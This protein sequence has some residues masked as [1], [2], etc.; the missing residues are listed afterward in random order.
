[1]AGE[2]QESCSSRTLDGWTLVSGAGSGIGAALAAAFA[3]A[4]HPVVLTDV[5]GDAARQQATLLRARG[6]PAEGLTLDVTSAAEV[7]RVITSL[8]A[9]GK[10]ISVLINNAGLQH[11]SRL[12]DFPPERWGLLV[13]VMLKGPAM[14]TRACLPGMRRLG[15][16][17]V[18]NI[19]SLHS[20]VASPYKSAYIAAKHGLL[21]LAKTV[22]LETG[23]TDITIN[24]LCPGYVRTPLVERQIAAQAREHG[25]PEERVVQE[26]MLRP[27]PK[28]SFITVDELAALA[29]FLCT[30]AARNITAQAIAIDGGW[31]AA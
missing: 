21:G 30:D 5:D 1:M 12:E 20:L 26:I 23:D 22:A 25:L 13:D 15:Y 3:A 18:I 8:E 24:T 4:G 29:L 19:G 27:M 17:R 2:K 16:G 7:E 11:V 10:P 31:T 9:S 28:K 6:Y 14:L